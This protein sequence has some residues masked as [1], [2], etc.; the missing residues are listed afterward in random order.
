MRGGG[1]G[2]ERPADGGGVV[3]VKEDRW[4]RMG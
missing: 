1:G 2:L 4:V 3:G